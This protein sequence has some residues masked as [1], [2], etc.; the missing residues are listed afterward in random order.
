MCGTFGSCRNCAAETIH[1][2][3][4]APTQVEVD[5][6]D[7]NVQLSLAYVVVEGLDFAS[8]FAKVH[9]GEPGLEKVRGERV[10]DSGVVY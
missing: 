10:V 2:R 6:M 8:A 5:F 7:V 3:S 4:V 9:D 1:L